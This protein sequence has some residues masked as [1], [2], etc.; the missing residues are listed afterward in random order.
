[1]T[2]TSLWLDELLPAEALRQLG[3][4]IGACAGTAARGLPMTASPMVAGAI[5]DLVA[6]AL[7]L[8]VLALLA[9]GWGLAAEIRGYRDTSK[10]PKGSVGVVKLGAHSIQR[11]VKPVIVLDFGGSHRFP[12]DVAIR[13]EAAFR[14][15]ELSIQ[16]ACITAV[17]CGSCDL[18]VQPRIA[19]NALCDARRLEA[20][21]LPG[22]HTFAP[23]IAIS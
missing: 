8:D 3:G 23:P 19:G 15:V 2:A 18:S 13:L 21:R 4:A 6:S 1:M 20:W 9:Q 17:G 14:G 10:H 5:Q 22:R 11:D 7:H 16:D 12:V